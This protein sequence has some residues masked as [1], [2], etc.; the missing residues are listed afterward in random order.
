[1]QAL[2][3]AYNE[4]EELPDALGSLTRLRVL[5]VSNNRLAALPSSFSSL[6]SLQEINLSHNRVRKIAG[7]HKLR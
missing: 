4:M 1:M 3:M 2:V 5:D 6:V 7:I